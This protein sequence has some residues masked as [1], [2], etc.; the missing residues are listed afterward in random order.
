MT[1]SEDADE[2][3]E[4]YEPADSPLLSVLTRGDRRSIVV[5]ACGEVDI[6]TADLLSGCAVRALRHHPLRLTL[7]LSGV[8][9]FSAAGLR[10]LIHIGRAAGAEVTDF[11]LRAPSHSVLYVLDLADALDQFRVDGADGAHTLDAD[12]DADA[13]EK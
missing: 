2:P 6:G 5:E 3:W 7:D 9:F 1:A 4:L 10:A 13:P 11:R 12:A 8:T